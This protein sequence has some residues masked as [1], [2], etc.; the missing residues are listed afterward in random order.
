MI[1]GIDVS[2]WQGQVNWERA[3]AAGVAFVF[4]KL[5]EGIAAFDQRFIENYDGAEAMGILRGAYHFFRPAENP[6]QQANQF[7]DKWSRYPCELPPVLDLEDRKYISAARAR[8]DALLWLNAV[9]VITGRV[10]IIYTAPAYAN[11]VI[12]GEAA[13][14]RYPLWIANYGV[15]TPQVPKPWKAYTFWQ[16]TDRGDGPAHGTQSKSVDLDW[17]NGDEAALLKLCDLA[18][19]Q[20]TP[21]PEPNP[22]PA[23]SRVRVTAASLNARSE[24]RVAA[25]TARMLATR[26]QVYDVERVQGDWVQAKVWLHK[27][28]VEQV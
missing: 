19:S 27:D 16:H 11:E 12:S 14:A 20:P 26:G 21:Q 24:P 28:Y 7:I 2:H 25:D 9:E 4:L 6:L 8:S 17:F 23:P 15:Q 5:T 1:P 10:P 18:P 22:A 3:K 13:F